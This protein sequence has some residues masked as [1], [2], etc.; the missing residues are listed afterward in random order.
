MTSI[1]AVQPEAEQDNN[2]VM[3][4]PDAANLPVIPSE[5]PQEVLDYAGTSARGRVQVKR[6]KA[7]LD[8][9]NEYG[10]VILSQHHAEGAAEQ[11]LENSDQYATQRE[12]LD[13]IEEQADKYL[14]AYNNLM[15]DMEAKRAKVIADIV[16]SKSTD[17]NYEDAF[18]EYQTTFAALKGNV[19]N[20]QAAGERVYAAFKEF[21]KSVPSAT[22]LVEGKRKGSRSNSTMPG[23]A[24]ANG[25][26]AWRPTFDWLEIQKPTD[27]EFRRLPDSVT[28]IGALC[29][30]EYGSNTLY[31]SILANL[32][33]VTGGKAG[34]QDGVTYE[35]SRSVQNEDDGSEVITRY[36]G[37]AMSKGAKNARAQAAKD[38]AE[39]K[40]VSN[41]PAD[42]STPDTNPDE[43]AIDF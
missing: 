36:R 39:G 1:E 23:S 8:E 41:T 30:A 7:F 33:T 29:K 18:E 4:K 11:E 2:N 5:L 15:A 17:V 35:W 43:A 24:N 27:Q 13:S 20:Y 37:L 3:P 14:T 31:D 38:A 21:F 6:A 12:E 40:P 28:S 16:A 19:A 42:V 26:Q 10:S 9:L 32:A 34:I 22:S 25:E